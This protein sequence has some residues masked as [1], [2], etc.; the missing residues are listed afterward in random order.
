SRGGRRELRRRGGVLDRA[1]PRRRARRRTARAASPSSAG[2]RGPGGTG[3]RDRRAGRLLPRPRLARAGGRVDAARAVADPA[4]RR[5]ALLA[6]AV[7]DGRAGAAPRRACR[8]LGRDAA[9]GGGALILGP[10]R[11]ARALGC[12]TEPGSPAVRFLCR[13]S[14]RTRFRAG[15]PGACRKEQKMSGQLPEAQAER[16][17]RDRARDWPQVLGALADGRDLTAADTAWVMDEIMSDNAT[18]AQIAAFGV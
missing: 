3:V 16:A 2:T 7:E 18:S 10:L 12:S 6:G 14:M 17:E 15:R 9:S 1:G 5:V 11:I 4:D 13:I 8:R